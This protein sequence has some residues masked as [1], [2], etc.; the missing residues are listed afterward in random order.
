MATFDSLQLV[1]VGDLALYGHLTESE[2]PDLEARGQGEEL[3]GSYRTLI[4][5]APMVV[6]TR[7]WNIRGVVYA[8]HGRSRAQIINQLNALANRITDVIAVEFID[9]DSDALAPYPKFAASGTGALWLHNRGRIRDISIGGEGVNL[10][11]RISLELFAFWQALN[12]AIWIMK[13]RNEA[14]PRLFRKAAFNPESDIVALPEAKTFFQQDVPYSFQKRIYEDQTFH[15]DPDYFMALQ[16]Q[17]DRDLPVLRYASDWDVS[18]ATAHHIFIDKARW[19]APPLSIYLFKNMTSASTFTIRVEYESEIW[20]L[21]EQTTS[22][23]VSAID[24]AMTDEGYTLADTDI[25]VVGDVENGAFILRDGE[26]LLHVA[27]AVSRSGGDWAGQL[28]PGYNIVTVQ[29]GTYAQ[30]HVYRRL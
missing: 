30:H 9:N 28:Q 21:A 25:L 18:V 8:T 20:E 1:Q 2:M 16:A 27:D 14:V 13:R 3:L 4:P 26:K 17:H 22:I 6:E 23:D 29:G 19:S 5:H 12:P 15:Y 11:L 24:T 7:K 10:D